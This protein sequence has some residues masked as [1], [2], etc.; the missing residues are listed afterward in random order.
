MDAEVTRFINDNSFIQDRQRY[1]GA[2]VVSTTE[3]IWAE[4]LL[5]EMTAQKAES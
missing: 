4:P 2:V 1:A 3:T 5:V